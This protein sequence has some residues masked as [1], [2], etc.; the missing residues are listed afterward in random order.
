MEYH[1]PVLL[2]SGMILLALF[3]MGYIGVKSKI[4]NVILFMLLGMVVGSFFTDIHLLQ[5]FGEIGII[6]LFFVLGMEFP[7]NRLIGIASKVAPAGFI[8]V[9]L[10]FG[11]TVVICYM[12]GADLLTGLLI[13]GIV[14]TTSSSIT[15]K[16]LE[17]TKRTA[18]KESEF[19]LGLLIFEDLVAPIIV[20]VLVGLTD[21]TELSGGSYLFIV[22][23][24]I[25]MTIVAIFLGKVVFKRLGK[26]VERHIQS[27]FFILFTV[28][29]A[30]FYGGLALHLGL[31][32]S[33]GRSWLE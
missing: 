11:V 15:A 18:N 27:D 16:L 28:G 25:L 2:V 32:K 4:P 20:A 19:I 9:A 13:G 12:F 23:K 5:L 29:I 22:L 3:L 17:T 24:I 30:L 26:F 33:W 14:Y 1:Y 31:L 7:V 8:D 21:G 10:N 6:L